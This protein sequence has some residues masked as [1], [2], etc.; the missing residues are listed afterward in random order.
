MFECFMS[1][2]RTVKSQIRGLGKEQQLFFLLADKEE[3]LF[4]SSNLFTVA[5]LLARALWPCGTGNKLELCPQLASAADC[6]DPP[7]S[8]ALAPG[9]NN[10][11][12]FS[13]CLNKLACSHSRSIALHQASC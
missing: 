9:K 13:D 10:T 11:S 5:V 12:G 1:P 7:Q 6:T 4:S 8:C 2:A 3:M